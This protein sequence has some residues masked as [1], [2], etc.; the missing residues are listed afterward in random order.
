M[1]QPA[2]KLLALLAREELNAD[3]VHQ[4]NQRK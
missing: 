2:E 4:I 3:T 1:T